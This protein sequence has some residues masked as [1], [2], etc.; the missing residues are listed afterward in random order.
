[1]AIVLYV[2]AHPFNH[3]THSL[4][5]CRKFME[6][7]R[8]VNPNDEIIH[9]DLY[10]ENIPQFDA[11]LLQRWGQPPAGPSFEELSKESQAKALRVHALADQFVAADKV[12]I[13][14][15]VWNF[16]IPPLLKTYIDAINIPGK[17]FKRSN[18][19]MRGLGGLEGTQKG[20]KVVHIQA[21]GTVLSHGK[22][23]DVELSHRYVKAVMNFMG[24]EHVEAIYAEGMHER[25]DLAQKIIELAMEQARTIAK[26]F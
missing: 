4:S 19:G 16:S 6:T 12:V 26:R 25:P 5:V 22:Y 13:A 10:R 21:S 3:D 15:P 20:K 8:E 11:D 17:T 2:T 1:M 18:N 14:N 7:Y 23:Q 24:I 9:L